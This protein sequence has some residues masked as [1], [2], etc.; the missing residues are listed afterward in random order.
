M[1]IHEDNPCFSLSAGIISHNTSRWRA[2]QHTVPKKTELMDLRTTRFP[3]GIK[4]KFDY[5]QAEVRV[6]AK[7][8]NDTALLAAFAS[9]MDFHRYNASMMWD[10]PIDEVTDTERD[11]AKG[12]TFS[13]LFGTSATEFANSYTKGNIK[14]ARAIMNSFLTSYPEV[15]KYIKAMHRRGAMTNTVPTLFGNPLYINMP[16]WV[17]QLDTYNRE[18]LVENPY[19][20]A[21]T[22]PSRR[23]LNEEDE[24]K[25][26]ALFSKALRN[27]QNAG[28]QGTSSLLA[29]LAIEEFQEMI[30]EEGLSAKLECFTHDSGEADLRAND[31]FKVLEILPIASVDY[32]E[33]EH[34]VLMKIDYDIGVSN[35]KMVNLEDAVVTENSIEAGF[36][37]KKV[38]LDL[39]KERLAASGITLTYEV[40]ESEEQMISVKALFVTTNAYAIDTGKKFE[41]LKGTLKITREGL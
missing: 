26:R 3:D 12:V 15:A 9:G 30:E 39:L 14:E 2:S 22:I 35:N 34:D 33:K 25:E 24:R 41:V 4:L 19:N 36:K 10:K 21:V 13:L 23:V 17:S 40:E 11:M 37:G 6:L 8:S 31:L 38:A 28:I 18:L 1:T 20:P 29:G 7:L 27:C 5:S 32:L 16:I